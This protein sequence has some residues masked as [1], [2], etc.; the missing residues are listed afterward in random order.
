MWGIGAM[1]WGGSRSWAVWAGGWQALAAAAS[2]RACLAQRLAV[3]Q[4]RRH[5]GSALSVRGAV[6]LVV[7][8]L[9][10]VATACLVHRTLKPPCHNWQF[11]HIYSQQIGLSGA[12]GGSPEACREIGLKWRVRFFSP[13]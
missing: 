6:S 10:R 3:A 2:S 9:E 12:C 13:C 1:D 5:L 8:A 4:H 7:S 11:C